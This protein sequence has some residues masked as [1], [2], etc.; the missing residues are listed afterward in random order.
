M[1]KAKDYY[2][3]VI[4]KE[5]YTEIIKC[6]HCD[7]KF[8]ITEILLKL[9]DDNEDQLDIEVKSVHCPHCKEEL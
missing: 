5:D 9:T 2:S 1:V 7:N 6:K 4:Y 3:D 8:S